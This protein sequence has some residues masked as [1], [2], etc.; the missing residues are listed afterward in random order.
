MRRIWEFWRVYGR[1]IAERQ[2]TL[3]LW[4]IYV[5]VVGPTWLAWRLVGHSEFGGRWRA[6]PKTPATLADLR[7]LG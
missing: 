2:T 1:L 6:R 4:I 5:G 3:W 7:R